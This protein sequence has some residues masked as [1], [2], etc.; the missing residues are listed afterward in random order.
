[1]SYYKVLQEFGRGASVFNGSWTDNKLT[2]DEK[3]AEN[4]NKTTDNV[5]RFFIFICLF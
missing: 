1:M 5:I 3:L 2:T 4:K